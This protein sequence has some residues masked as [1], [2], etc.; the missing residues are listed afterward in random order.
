MIRLAT[1]NDAA[2]VAAIYNH[3]VAT[4]TISF[5]EHAVAADEMAKRIAGT[6]ARACHGMCSSAT[7]P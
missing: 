2:A 1:S 4:S 6:W 7:A 3:Y 5:E